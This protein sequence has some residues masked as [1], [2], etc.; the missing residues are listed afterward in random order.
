MAS[1]R[2]NFG[3]AWGSFDDLVSINDVVEYFR[4]WER[5]ERA[6]MVEDYDELSSSSCL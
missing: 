3:L 2:I 1:A 6:T 5:I 4:W